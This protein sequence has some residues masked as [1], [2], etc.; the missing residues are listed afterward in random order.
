MSRIIKQGV[1]HKLLSFERITDEQLMAEQGITKPQG[2]NTLSASEW[3]DSDDE[4][5]KA[6][7]SKK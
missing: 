7:T 3:T 2:L 6:L 4:Y 5:L 1:R